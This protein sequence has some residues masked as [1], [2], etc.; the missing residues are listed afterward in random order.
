M[1]Q[2]GSIQDVV[3]SYIQNVQA[4]EVLGPCDKK[5]SETQKT[6]TESFSKVYKAGQISENT[7]DALL[8][9]IK[10]QLN[11]A[12]A[13]VKASG[14]K[15]DKQVVAKRTEFAAKDSLRWAASFVYDTAEAKDFAARQALFAQEEKKL[16]D[17]V[18][19]AEGY[20]KTIADAKKTLESSCLKFKPANDNREF[21]DMNDT[22][23]GTSIGL[24]FKPGAKTQ[25]TIQESKVSCQRD[26]TEMLNT[27][28]QLEQNDEIVKRKAELL[29]SAVQRC[30]ATEFEKTLDYTVLKFCSK[31]A[32]LTMMD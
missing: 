31:E 32:Y 6:V 29:S 25:I 28:L 18:T 14:S 15:V 9:L 10:T 20:A 1:A 27:L 26:L 2:V 3:T 22:K 7:S 16:K 8:A 19:V 4:L 24:Y 17:L 5:V 23:L 11:I 13:A 30:T 12:E 21:I